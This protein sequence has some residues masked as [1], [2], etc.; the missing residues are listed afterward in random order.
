MNVISTTPTFPHILTSQSE[1]PQYDP[2][3][4]PSQDV[5]DAIVGP[6]GASPPSSQD[7]YPQDEG[8]EDDDPDQPRDIE[9]VR[10]HRGGLTAEIDTMQYNTMQFNAMNC[11]AMQR[12]TMKHY[13][14]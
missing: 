12:N 8:V 11:D 5:V 1:R 4:P 7:P 2:Y 13:T 14:T 3:I 6:E 10:Q 9:A